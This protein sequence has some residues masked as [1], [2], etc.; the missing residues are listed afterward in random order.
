MMTTVADATTQRSAWIL[1]M[2]EPPYLTNRTKAPCRVACTPSSHHRRR[3]ERA[4]PYPF[5]DQRFTVSVVSTT[6]GTFASFAVMV[7]VVLFDAGRLVDTG[8]V[9]L[10]APAGTGMLVET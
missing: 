3:A 2:T 10:V 1:F 4:G 9:A 6:F 5:V 8:N 7:T